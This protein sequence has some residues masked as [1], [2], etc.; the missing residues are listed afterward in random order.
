[1]ASDNYQT[2]YKGVCFC[3]GLFVDF[4]C[5]TVK[6]MGRSPIPIQNPIRIEGAVSRSWGETGPLLGCGRARKASKAT[7]G[8][9]HVCNAVRLV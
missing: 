1:M 7:G 3:G 2:M 8:L 4:W 5:H 9:Q 6:P